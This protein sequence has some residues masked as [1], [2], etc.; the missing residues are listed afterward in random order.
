MKWKLQIKIFFILYSMNIL[1]SQDYKIQFATIPTGQGLASGDSVGVLNSIGGLLSQESS[2]DS[3]IV[4]EGFLKTSQ[5]VFSEPPLISNF[6]LPNLINKSSGSITVDATLF[7]LNGINKAELYLQ[8]GG[9]TNELILPMVEGSEGQYQIIISDSLIGVE[10][11]RARVIAVDNMENLSSSKYKTV[12]VKFSSGEMTMAHENSSYP[13][14]IDKGGWRL[15]SWPG[16][17]QD[18]SLSESRLEDGHIFYQYQPLLEEYVV[19][20]MIEIGSAYW[21]KHKYNEPVVFEE[22]TSSSLPLENYTISLQQGWNMIGS[23]F[24][25]SVPFEKDSTV[26]DLITYGNQDKD[27]WSSSQNTFEPW[28]GYAVYAADTATITLLPFGETN[29]SAERIIA[30]D[31]WT[32]NLRLESDSYFNF[33]TTVGRKIHAVNNLDSYDTPKLIDLNNN[34]AVVSKLVGLKTY[35][36]I[37]DIRSTDDFNGVWDLRL[38]SEGD[39]ELLLFSGLFQGPIPKDLHISIVDIQKR[40]IE[41]DFLSSGFEIQNKSS[42]SYDLKFVAGDLDYVIQ[43]SEDILEDIPDQYALSQNYPNPFNPITRMNYQLP[44]RSR[45]IISIYNIMGQEVRTLLNQD[46]DYGA[47]S[48]TWNG[49]DQF[50]KTMATGVYFARMST[51]SF[52]QT[53]KMLL[54]K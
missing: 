22:D 38:E 43:K 13:E 54:L 26:G 24:S 15:I 36:Y 44:K 21:F 12:E 17:P 51:G 25:F 39:Q 11:F 49:V 30:S 1:C 3:F 27:G 46:Q 19:P 33:S 29:N 2:S 28:N 37:R 23:P 52:S 32:L 31:E 9:T 18:L 10:N 47:H 53:K 42:L 50:G 48:I 16:V 20:D 34:L 6:N 5:N 4:G 7:D 40:S 8:V 35:N 41:Y 45:V 14:G